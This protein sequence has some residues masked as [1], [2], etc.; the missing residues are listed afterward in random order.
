[1]E[2]IKNY[3]L[4][5]EEQR[6]SDII[7]FIDLSIN[8]SKDLKKIWHDTLSKIKN[9][10]K[11][12]KRKILRYTIYSLLT[13]NT[14]M[15]VSQII[16][17]S[18]DENIIE[19]AEEILDDIS[20]NKY[21]KGYEWEIS[22]E[23]LD[24]IKSEEGLRLKAYKIGDG[25]ITVGYGHAEPIKNSKFKVGD[26]ITKNKAEELLKSDLKVATDGVRK[27]FKEWENKGI[28]IKITQ[29]MFD[30]L[31]SIAY[32][33]G[34]GALRKSEL[35]KKLKKGEYEDVANNILNFK[36]SNKFPGLEKR[37]KKESEMFLTKI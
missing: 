20:E 8:E 12:S 14:F 16:K 27:I 17:S 4:Y 30:A 32:N 35:I 36:T 28:Y 29:N 6:V 7:K 26:V 34:V 3:N 5:F 23:G 24:H 33:T 11:E 19:I 37:R 13:F 9:L 18:F 22:Q 25:K 10:S 15:N 21:R 1:M 31:V 2:N